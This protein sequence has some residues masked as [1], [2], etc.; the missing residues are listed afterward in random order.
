MRPMV[1]DRDEM[2]MRDSTGFKTMVANHALLSD[3][4]GYRCKFME[5]N[6]FSQQNEPASSE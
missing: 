3:L 1:H 2:G 5:G 6:D 4:H